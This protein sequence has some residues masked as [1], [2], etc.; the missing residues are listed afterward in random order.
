MRFVYTKKNVRIRKYKEIEKKLGTQ[1]NIRNLL[2]IF[3]PK[4]VN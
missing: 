2:I 4:A 3:N 1:D